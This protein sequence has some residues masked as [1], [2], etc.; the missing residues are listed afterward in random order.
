MDKIVILLLF[1]NSFLLG[2]TF[3]FEKYPVGK[4]P[5]SWA[6]VSTAGSTTK[7]QVIKE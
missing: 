3:D 6:Q 5:E 1:L 4:L 2:I 7:W